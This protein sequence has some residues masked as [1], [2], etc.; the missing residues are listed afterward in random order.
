MTT[1][2]LAA[3]LFNGRET[4]F[5]TLLGEALKKNHAFD[6]TIPQRDGFEFGRLHATLQA[7]LPSEEVKPA[8][9]EIIYYLDMGIF[10]PESDVIVAN[11]DEPQDDGVLVEITY[12]HMMGIPVVGYRTDVRA[13]YGDTTDTG[14][15]A[16]FFPV[17]QCDQFILVKMPNRNP[18]E[19]A[20]GIADLAVSISTEIQQIDLTQERT[21]TAEMNRICDAARDLFAGI[22][23]HH[24]ESGM[25]EIVKRYVDKRGAE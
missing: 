6:S 9:E 15:G 18:E 21:M 7:S 13:P 10:I 24:S 23:D 1:I 4:A 25:T 14:G 3:A 12:A 16:H 11:L 8:V 19:L 5:N 22:D 17:R 2:Y 20:S